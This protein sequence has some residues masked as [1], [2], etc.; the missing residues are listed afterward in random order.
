M[1]KR[2]TRKKPVGNPKRKT[3]P[4]LAVQ[5]EV[6]R[7]ALYKWK[8]MEGA[9]QVPDLEAWQS[10]IAANDLG[11][12]GANQSSDKESLQREKLR[13]EIAL[14]DVKVAQA[15]RQVIDADEVEEIYTHIASRM[16]A[17]LLQWAQSEIPPIHAGA[18]LAEIRASYQEVADKLLDELAA[19][20]KR[21]LRENDKQK[22]E[23]K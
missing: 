13:R 14:L 20:W 19:G 21:W 9:P 5:L 16:R 18:D 10:F 2:D 22:G 3:W 1:T 6:S 8:Q 11:V 15:R 7:N 23:G 12:S 17:E 4:A